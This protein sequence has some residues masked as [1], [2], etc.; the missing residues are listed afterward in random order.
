MGGITGRGG[1]HMDN[2]GS[3]APG[4]VSTAAGGWEGADGDAPLYV[5]T[6]ASS[7]APLELR[8]PKAPQLA[9]LA[10][11][12]SRQ[13]EEGR[14]RFRLHIGYFAS[15]A[16]AEDVLPVVRASHPAAMVSLAPQACLGSLEDTASA[17]FTILRPATARH[18]AQQSAIPRPA[19]AAPVIAAPA[20]VAVAAVP[21]A[22]LV[23]PAAEK[24]AESTVVPPLLSAADAVSV[25][26]AEPLAAAAAHPA[27]TPAVAPVAAEAQHYAVQLLWGRTA[28]D[29]A[30]I[31]V[32]AIYSGYLLYAVE[33][34]PG[35]RRF[36]GVRLGFYADATS[37]RLVAQYVRSEFKG[38][39]VVPVSSREMAR[40]SSAAIRLGPTRNAGPARWP[41]TAL[42]VDMKNLGRAFTPAMM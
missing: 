15:A 16:A 25:P 3:G 20:P 35:P 26:A 21:D 22:P 40:A 6:L 9:G 36:F 37:A 23:M 24:P 1:L 28:I 13:V 11:F 38:V 14:E 42:P 10:V 2:R 39:A 18:G 34:E 7:T 30:K 27:A 41:R 29:L 32:L 8:A 5:V 17:R 33:T 31:P 4:A 19:E 12:R